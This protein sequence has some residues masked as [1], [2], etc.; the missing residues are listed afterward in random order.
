MANKRLKVRVPIT[1]EVDVE[2]WM[3]EYGCSS[4]EEVRADVKRHVESIVR[5]HLDSLRLSA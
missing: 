1:V 3:D 4:S 2:D 5:A